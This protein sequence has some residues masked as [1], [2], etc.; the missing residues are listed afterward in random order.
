MNIPTEI[1]IAVITA[2]VVAIA[3]RL[4]R[5]RRGAGDRRPV[6]V[7]DAL[8]KQAEILA[9]Q[10]PFLAKVC[11]DYRANGH[12]SARQADAVAKAL[13]RYS[14]KAQSQ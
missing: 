13:R 8:M 3:I 11:R 10:S 4:Y 9:G 6:H 12:I 5:A 2:T 14:S 7:H 1:L